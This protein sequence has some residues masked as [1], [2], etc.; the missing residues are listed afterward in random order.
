[1]LKTILYS[2]LILEY[3][4][5]PWMISLIYYILPK[6]MATKYPW[7][8]LNFSFDATPGIYIWKGLYVTF[9]CKRELKVCEKDFVRLKIRKKCEK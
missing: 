3:S 7:A 5:T 4:R 1:M 6:C 8:K 2:T 9:R